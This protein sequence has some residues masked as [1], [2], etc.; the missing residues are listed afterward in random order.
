MLLLEVRFHCGLEKATN[1]MKIRWE[2]SRQS[3]ES[4]R[5]ST[6]ASEVENYL[7]CPLVFPFQEVK[8]WIALASADLIDKALS[9]LL[10]FRPLCACT[11][12]DI[13]QVL[14]A[15]CL[16]R[17]LSKRDDTAK[18]DVLGFL[19][20]LASC[21][22]QKVPFSQHDA[23][24][25]PAPHQGAGAS[26]WDMR[27]VRWHF[28]WLA[29]VALEVHEARA[30]RGATRRG[31]VV[32]DPSGDFPVY[33]QG[34]VHQQKGPVLAFHGATCKFI[35]IHNNLMSKFSSGEA[36]VAPLFTALWM[37]GHYTATS[38]QVT[39]DD[40]WTA[41]HGFLQSRGVTRVRVAAWSLGCL[42]A[43]GFLQRYGQ[44]Y[45]VGRQL[46][47]EPLGSLA[48]CCLSYGCVTEPVGAVYAAF[49]P[50]TS[51]SNYQRAFGFACFMKND[52]LSRCYW[53]L[54][55]LR[56][57]L[58]GA[59]ALVNGP[60]TLVL[61]STDDP[62]THADLQDD[63]YAKVYFK[64]SHI[65]TRPGFHGAWTHS[66]LLKRAVALWFEQGVAIAP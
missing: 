38:H 62:L 20:E 21:I 28:P 48:S 13:Y 30:L 31:L 51:A 15:I 14:G 59:A 53:K 22:R 24:Q 39:V 19:R 52:A 54:L 56:N 65:R 27:P 7:S 10:G 45:E 37:Y 11:E 12:E 40:F 66:P 34:D 6:Q 35:A 36:V 49:K 63:M 16:L 17:P 47:I 44:F 25:H 43:T 60:Q 23:A 2:R 4:Q 26:F 55:P 32:H 18:A 41:L 58:W 46:Y 1:E 57:V 50:R 8:A 29:T 5:F 64:S 42:L 61:L 3:I 9:P 33:V